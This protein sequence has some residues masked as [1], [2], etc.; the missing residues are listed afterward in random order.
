MVEWRRM[1]NEFYPHNNF[2][3]HCIEQEACEFIDFLLKRFD[4]DNAGVSFA[5][6]PESTTTITTKD[7][8]NNNNNVFMYQLLA[9]NTA[10]LQ[11]M[12]VAGL[13]KESLQTERLCI[14]DCGDSMIL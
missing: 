11:I 2:N 9:P 6:N 14:D 8:N 12:R 1:L 4:G 3:S 7:N 13:L 5:L 10:L